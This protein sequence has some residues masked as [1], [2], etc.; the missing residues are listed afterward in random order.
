MGITVGGPATIIRF[1]G[2]VVTFVATT[3]PEPDAPGMRGVLN[4]AR[5]VMGITPASGLLKL[6]VVPAVQAIPE[7]PTRSARAGASMKSLKYTS[8][9]FHTHPM[10]R[11]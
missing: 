5:R 10:P 2:T 3:V 11:N 6:K 7:P 9:P 4:P 8:I 1:A